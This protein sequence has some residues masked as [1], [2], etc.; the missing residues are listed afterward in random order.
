MAQF[1]QIHERCSNILQSI[2]DWVSRKA[3]DT[4]SLC[5]FCAD[6]FCFSVREGAAGSFSQPDRRARKEQVRRFIEQQ[7]K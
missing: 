6:G 7:V 3:V 1:L 5:P 2:L 4:I